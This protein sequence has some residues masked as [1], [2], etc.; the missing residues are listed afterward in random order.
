MSEALR[1]DDSEAGFTLLEVVVA[2]AVMAASLNVI[3]PVISTAVGRIA[4]AERISQARLLAQSMLTRVGREIPARPGESFGHDERG[5]HWRIQQTSFE[6][7]GDQGPATSLVKI[8][9]E[10]SWGRGPSERRIVLT[11]LRPASRE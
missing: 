9:A 5:Y 1:V 2:L 3:L 10:V 7:P 6:R 11:T 8:E 4:Q